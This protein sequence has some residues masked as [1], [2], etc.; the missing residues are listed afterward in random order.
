MKIR[1]SSVTGDEKT[2]ELVYDRFM[3]KTTRFITDRYRDR[4]IHRFTA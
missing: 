2:V 3:T 4:K 1:V